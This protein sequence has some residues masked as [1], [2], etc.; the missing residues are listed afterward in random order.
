MLSGTGAWSLLRVEAGM[1]WWLLQ[2]IVID[3]RQWIFHSNLTVSTHWTA[4]HGNTSPFRFVKSMWVWQVGLKTCIQ[5]ALVKS[6]VHVKLVKEGYHHWAQKKLQ[7]ITQKFDLKEEPYCTIQIKFN[8]INILTNITHQIWSTF[9]PS[10]RNSCWC[11]LWWQSTWF[12]LLPE[13]YF[14]FHDNS[15]LQIF[16]NIWQLMQESI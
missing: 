5:R 10:G 12:L 9:L 13:V 4:W 1:D 2:V 3:M 16:W 8:L 11:S 15:S 7:L 14:L 6:A